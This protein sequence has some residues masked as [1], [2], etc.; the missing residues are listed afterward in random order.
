ME[1]VLNFL[2]WE[3]WSYQLKWKTLT[4]LSN[5]TKIL[6]WILNQ[7]K[8]LQLWLYILLLSVV[9]LCVIIGMS[10]FLGI[11]SKAN[12]QERQKPK[13]FQIEICKNVAIKS[14]AFL[15]FASI[16]MLKCSIISKYCFEH[17]LLTKFMVFVVDRFGVEW[18][19]WNLEC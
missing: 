14:T 13:L 12:W 2:L 8:L 11:K 6:F 15:Q 5:M 10:V 18:L 3:S 7:S 19:H 9:L 17:D 16:F 1:Y 4:Y